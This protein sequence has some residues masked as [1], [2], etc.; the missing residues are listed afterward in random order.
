MYLYVIGPNE[1]PQKIGLSENVQR[2]LKNLQT[3]HPHKLH[4]HHFE[5]VPRKQVRAI[6][7]RI[8][9]ELNYKKLKGEWFDIT[10]QEAIEFLIYFNILLNEER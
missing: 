8:H 2:R 3:G 6:E 10:K 4:I 5:E 1:G 7:K 9:T